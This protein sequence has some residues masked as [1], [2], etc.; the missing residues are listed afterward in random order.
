MARMIPEDAKT[1]TTNGEE[2]VYKFLEYFAKPDSQY[3]TWYTPDI[4]DREPDFI[5]FSNQYGLI[6]F[7]VKD[8]EFK[9][10]KKA[11][12]HNFLV[13]KGKKIED[14]P[15][16]M[17]QAKGYMHALFNRFKKDGTFFSSRSKVNGKPKI[18]VECGVIFPNIRKRDYHHRA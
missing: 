11:T 17:R 12:P 7:E 1:F 5:L 9:Q 13:L 16:P 6:I 4:E 14:N 15:N 2:R 18:P 10:I 3:M 8:W